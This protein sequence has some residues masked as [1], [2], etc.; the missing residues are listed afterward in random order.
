M[1]R[2]LRSIAGMHTLERYAPIYGLVQLGLFMIGCAFWIDARSGTSEFS[3]TTWGE[4]AY[5][6]PAEFWAFLTMTGACAALVGLIN[7]VKRGMVLFGGGLHICQHVALAYSAALT[8]GDIA[9]A[10]YA[11]FLLVPFHLSMFVGA[12]LQWKT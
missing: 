8:G 6:F 5:S 7:P 2:A 12:A 1:D 3:P 4:F 11:A 9:V 10:L